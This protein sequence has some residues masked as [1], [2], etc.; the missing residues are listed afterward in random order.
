[1]KSDKRNLIAAVSVLLVVGFLATSLVSYFTSSARIRET[2]V[3]S[4]LPL[5]SD[6]IYSEI[7]RDLIRPI[8]ISSMMASDTFMR[9]WVLA[10]ERDVE[11]MTKFLREVMERY[12][13]FT[14]FFISEATRTYYHADGILKKVHEDE[15]RDEWY[16]RVRRMAPNYEINVDPDMANQDAMTIFINYRVFGYD[17]KFIGATGV[18]LTVNAVRNLIQEYQKRYQ[19]TVYFVT[20]DGK[21]VL[22]SDVSFVPEANITEREGMSKIAAQLRPHSTGTFE[23]SRQ[24]GSHLLNIRFIPELNWYLFVEKQEDEA[25]RGLRQTL[26]TNLAICALITV[27]VLVATWLTINRYQQRLEAMATTDKLTGLASRHACDILL[28]QA[29]GDSAR[30]TEPLSIMLI[31]IDRLN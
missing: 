8:L 12:G 5:T 3:V 25:L 21:I 28:G 15:W 6:N 29:I 20:A 9:D 4:E 10:G 31:D 30:S 22:V 26:Y 13:A 23:Y 1:M 16:F 18:G 2:I 14:S 19:R 24:G 17:G 11:Q 7:Q 27:I